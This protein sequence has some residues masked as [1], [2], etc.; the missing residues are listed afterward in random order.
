[1]ANGRRF[2]YESPL[3]RLL[4]YT[5][6]TM[7]GEERDRQDRELYRD[8]LK[9]EREAERIENTRRWNLTNNQS[10]EQYQ[11]RITEEEDDE[12]YKRGLDKLEI[13]LKERD[14]VKQKSQLEA[15]D[16]TALHPDIS[17]L[18]T[19]SI[20]GLDTKIQEIDTSMGRFSAEDYS[21]AELARIRNQFIMGSSEGAYQVGDK[22]IQ[23]RYSTPW[24][25]VEALRIQ[26]EITGIN[27]EIAE[28]D[29]AKLIAGTETKEASAIRSDL[30][31]RK[32]SLRGDLA[33]LYDQDRPFDP[34]AYGVQFNANLE[35][36]LK[37]AGIELKGDK[38]RH[39]GI[40]GAFRKEYLTG[41]NASKYT[42]KQRD[43]AAQNVIDEI[44]KIETDD[45]PSPLPPDYSN[46]NK[47]DPAGTALLAVGGYKLAKGGARLA[48]EPTMKAYNYLSD[49]AVQASKHIK[50]VTGM[51]SKDIISFMESANSNRVGS[52]GRSMP[53]IEK[54][55]DLV[56]SLSDK[57]KSKEYKDAI[58]ALDDRVRSVSTSLKKRGI[59]TNI[60]D[61]DLEKLLK[62]PDKWRLAKLK[63]R[64]SKVYPGLKSGATKWGV[65]SA[66]AKIG[67]AL[68]DPTGGIATGIG[69]PA[70]TKKVINIYKKKGPKW[71]MAKLTPV[72]GKSIA[73]RIVGGAAA[74]AV[75]GPVASAGAAIAGTGLAVYDLYK[76]F[77]A[78][79]EEDD[80]KAVAVLRN[81]MQKDSTQAPGST[82]VVRPFDPNDPDSVLFNTPATGK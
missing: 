66:S 18:V 12:L 7:I 56:D 5:I 42:L 3:D 69:L 21:P 30:E 4:N 63:G 24:V 22:I 72:M 70:V 25:K 35:T 44:I 28:I 75:G 10:I 50:F 16:G 2:N 55:K 46:I 67:E 27:A 36:Q 32:I 82:G 1:M 29:R 62:N 76:F 8:E 33:G 20:A 23:D 43:D 15:M 73:K 47:L 53:S 38:T 78:L 59:V 65:F 60:K 26:K 34:R 6:P 80:E 41:P 68:G 81:A 37:D 74:G 77:E 61:A 40:L 79:D 14:I 13:I 9:Q 57:P 64:F 71:L 11:A 58:K 17:A 19:S 54:A 49:K 39:A 31:Q 48:K 45:P 51:P 52:I